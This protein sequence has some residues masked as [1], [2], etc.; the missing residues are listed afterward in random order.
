VPWLRPTVSSS[1][2]ASNSS[3]FV[4]PP[5]SHLQVVFGATPYLWRKKSSKQLWPSRPAGTVGIIATKVELDAPQSKLD[6]IMNLSQSA[7]L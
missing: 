5:C 2:T 3:F 6:S 4:I 1:T 7:S